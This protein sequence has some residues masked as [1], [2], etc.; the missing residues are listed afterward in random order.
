MLAV[1]EHDYPG[2]QT[3]VVGR[4]APYRALTDTRPPGT[5]ADASSPSD[6]ARRSPRGVPGERDLGDPPPR[7]RGHET[8]LAEPLLR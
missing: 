3:R 2:Y 4:E 1:F 8:A 5:A 6:A 7:S